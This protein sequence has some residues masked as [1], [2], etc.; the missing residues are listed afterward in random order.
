[1]KTKSISF[2][3]FILTLVFTSCKKDE[4]LDDGHDHDHNHTSVAET[5]SVKISFTNFFGNDTLKLNSALYVNANNDTFTVSKFNY[6]I[7]NIKLTASDNSVYSESESYH[8]V[9][10]SDVSSH[11]FTLVNIPLKEYTSISFMI[12]VDSLRNVSG[13]Q[14]GAL[15]PLKGNF[16]DWNSGYIMAKFEGIT[17]DTTNLMFHIGGFSGS[18]NVLKTIVKSFSTNLNV[19]KSSVP[20]VRLNTDLAKWFASPNLIDF[21]T[22]KIIHMPGASA[23]KVADNY[24]FMFSSPQVS[25]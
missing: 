16:W 12:G 2:L 3:L 4:T 15:D 7:S 13:A 5:G 20:Q 25:N 1:M 10:H 19:T 11:A 6:Y 8:L 18:N 23:K 17:V 22:I 9:E 24:E 21:K 14:S